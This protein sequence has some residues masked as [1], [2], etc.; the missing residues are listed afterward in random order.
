MGTAVVSQRPSRF[1]SSGKEQPISCRPKG[2]IQ[3]R[4]ARTQRDLS[5]RRLNR[6]SHSA[7][8]EPAATVGDNRKQ[9]CTNAKYTKL[10]T[11]DSK[12]WAKWALS[13]RT[14]VT[15]SH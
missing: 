4:K 12:R 7:R 15:L 8:P 2:E 3:C 9:N 14:G 6:V 10:C 11:G 13:G 5:A 1:K